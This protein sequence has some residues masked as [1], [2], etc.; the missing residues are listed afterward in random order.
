MATRCSPANHTSSGV[1][2]GRTA[3]SASRKHLSARSCRIYFFLPFADFLPERSLPATDLTTFGVFGFLRSFAA[4]DAS[5][6]LVVIV[7]HVL[8]FLYLTKALTELR[9]L[10]TVLDQRHVGH[11]RPVG[12]HRAPVLAL[13]VKPD[14]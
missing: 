6:L 13:I 9:L 11:R 14:S 5:F 8:H 1:A 7:D 2:S 10:R 4:L 3:S 12:K